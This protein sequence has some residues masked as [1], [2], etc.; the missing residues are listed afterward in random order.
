MI[1]NIIAG[2]AAMKNRIRPLRTKLR[3]DPFR[4]R[5]AH[6]KRGSM[7]IQLKA[8]A[9]SQNELRMIDTDT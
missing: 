9:Q 4:L 5:N 1:G 8:I 2:A 6:T 3:N 7:P